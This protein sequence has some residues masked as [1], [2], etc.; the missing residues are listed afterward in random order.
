MMDLATAVQTYG[1]PLVFIGTFLE[2]ET[3]LLLAGFAAYRGYLDV[4]TVMLVALLAS[5][6]GDQLYFFLGRRYGVVILKR[7]PSLRPRI[8]RFTL[9]LHR[10]H[11]PLI[12]SIRFLYGLRIVGPIALGFTDIPWQRFMLLNFIGGV[13][14]AILITSIGYQFGNVL[15]LVME[16]LY[17]F[18][19]VGVL[20]LVALSLTIW[21][22]G[23]RR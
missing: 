9:L 2:G 16:N 18:E 13:V 22:A 6:L 17:R 15:E 10:Y 23:R 3:I 21:L 8:A 20:V 14:W 7:W 1:Y 11:T 12:L 19:L 4:T 5:F